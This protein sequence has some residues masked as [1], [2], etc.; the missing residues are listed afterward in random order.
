[1]PHLKY[2]I[3]AIMERIN[4]QAL[5][6]H[7]NI[8]FFFSTCFKL[9]EY[10]Q[11][12]LNIFRNSLV[13]QWFKTVFPLQ[14]ARVQSLVRELGSHMSGSTVRKQTNKQTNKIIGL[15]KSDDS[16]LAMFKVLY[17]SIKQY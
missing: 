5:W 6:N 12:I 13:V 9:L 15:E 7:W 17:F 10:E 2:S 1:M 14:A 4:N 11:L 16:M 3:D 8:E